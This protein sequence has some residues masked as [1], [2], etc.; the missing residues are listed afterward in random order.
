MLASQGHDFTIPEET[1]RIAKKAFRKG[2]PHIRLRDELG[3]LYEDNEFAT[4]FSSQGKPAAS[5]GYLAMVTAMQYMEGVS[6]RQAADN[7]RGRIDW[8]YALGLPLDDAGFDASIL[9]E[10]RSRLI[11]G[12]VEMRLLERLLEICQAHNLLTA[13]GQQRTDSSHVLG[14]VREI[15]RLEL[16]AETLRHALNSLA[17]TVPAWLAGQVPA[18]WFD[19][20]GA[21]L[22]AYRFPESKSARQELAETIGRDGYAL[23][24]MVQHADAP[25]WLPELPA[26]EIL[27]RI[28]VQNFYLEGAQVRLRSAENGPPGALRIQSP[29]D[30]EVRY[31]RKRQTEWVGYKVHLTETCEP[32]LP[33]LIT[34]VH[35]TPSSEPDQNAIKPIHQALADKQLLPATHIVDTGYI[36]AENLADSQVDHQVDLVGPAPPDTSWQAQSPTAFDLSTFAVDWDAQTV[37]C[38]AG[39]QSRVWSISQDRSHPVIHVQ[40]HKTT[41]LACPFRTQCT[42]ASKGPRTLKLR[43]KAEHIALQDARQ[44][45][46]LPAFKQLYST[47]AGV[48]GTISLGARSFDLR[49]ARYIGLAKTHL[50]QLCSAIA[51][52]LSRLAAWFQGHTVATTRISAFASLSP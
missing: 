31:S 6:D 10:F 12:N 43:V 25:A 4:L 15:N 34:H 20:Y 33:H 35:T 23:W 44:R 16:V 49:R 37:T 5:P 19:A 7:V 29:Y 51:I 36:D 28:W 38:P 30:V 2:N 46:T 50:Q 32:E 42:T 8:K 40:F 21:R 24:Q 17:S 48:E 22:D 52:N 18:S 3:I 9:S 26:V 14:A 11:A 41:C 13:R 39:A 45:Q 27:R 1:V 47:R